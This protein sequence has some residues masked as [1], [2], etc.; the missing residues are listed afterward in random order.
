M[1]DF[2]PM[3]SVSCLTVGRYRL[4]EPL[5]EGQTG[6]VYRAEDPLL[7]RE[8]ALKVVELPSESEAGAA[9]EEARAVA[10]LSHPALVPVFDF[11]RDGT[12]AWIAFEL[13]P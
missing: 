5:G 9:L 13:V 8:V 4:L 11:G 6:I 2:V 1:G 3:S 7:A 12:R 10:A